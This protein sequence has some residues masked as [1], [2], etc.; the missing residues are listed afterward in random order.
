MEKMKIKRM[1]MFYLILSQKTLKVSLIF[2]LLT[3]A[4]LFYY[5]H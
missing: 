5:Y 2:S 3:F 4:P 1:V